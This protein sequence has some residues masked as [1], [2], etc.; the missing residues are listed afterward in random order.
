MVLAQMDKIT[1]VDKQQIKQASNAALASILNL[2]FLPGIAFIWLILAIK[3]MP[4]TSIGYYHV[5]LGI[6]L[7]LVAFVALA[8]V[9]ALMIILGGWNSAWTWVYVITY[10]TFV[11]TTFIILAVWALTRAWSGLKLK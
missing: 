5:K 8:V 9:S 1:A 3:K 11:H 2:T 10:F 4:P 6:K 7:N